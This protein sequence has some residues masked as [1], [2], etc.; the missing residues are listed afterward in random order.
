[1]KNKRPPGQLTPVKQLLSRS[2]DSGFLNFMNRQLKVFALWPLAI[3]P[4]LA[5]QTK[6]DSVRD[7]RLT[8]LVAAPVWIDHLSYQKK[9][10]L[11]RLNKDLEPGEKIQDIIFKVGR[12]T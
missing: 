2:L 11:A 6:L 12:L 3:G 8:V 7:G 10:L 9:A 4:E 1:M 5:A